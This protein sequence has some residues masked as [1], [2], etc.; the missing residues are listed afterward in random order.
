[1]KNKILYITLIALCSISYGAADAQIIFS[2]ANSSIEKIER[3]APWLKSDNGAGIVYNGASNFSTIKSSLSQD[4]GAYKN[5]YDGDDNTFVNIGT[6]S[7]KRVKDVFFYGK[8]G[9]EYGQRNGQAWLG[10]IYP[11]TTVNPISDSIPGK[12]LREDYFLA[13]KVGYI[14]NEYVS[15]GFNVDYHSAVGAKRV[16]GR[17]SNTMS[18]LAISPGF[19]VN[20]KN[21]IWGLNFMLKHNVERVTYSFLG[22]VTGKSIYYFDGG[23]WFANELGITNTTNLT[24]GYFKD[25]YGIGSQ[26]EFR[27]GKFSF[28]NQYKFDY[29][30]EH[31]YEGSSLT[32]RYAYVDGINQQY[33]GVLSYKGE[34]MNHF[35][36]VKYESDEK[37]S[38]SIMSL[39][40]LIP[41]EFSTYAYFEY[42]RTLRYIQAMK[43]LEVVY[44]NYILKGANDYSWIINLGYQGHLVDKDYRIFPSSYHQDY[45]NQTIFGKITKNLKIGKSINTD[46][47]AGYGITTSSGT[48]LVEENPLSLEAMK[49][50]VNILNWDW[51][52]NSADRYKIDL[53]LKISKT[54]NEKMGRSIYGAVN[55]SIIKA[56]ELRE[57][58]SPFSSDLLNRNTIEVRLGYN[59]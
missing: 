5:F 48:K 18:Y 34:K 57:T 51:A 22:D 38:Y 35:I 29:L 53:G 13:T 37:F 26:L 1:M 49:M 6:E 55:Y 16:D 10:T 58:P 15:L 14:F 7:Y 40:E 41:G 56:T 59:F 32:K 11:N 21:V 3:A 36:D 45:L 30:N 17:N 33:N 47:Y 27:F 23:L 42:G 19:T 46:L 52:Y 25:F 31:D 9:Y 28:F 50:N 44:S 8:F 39:Y 54:L 12:F 2:K 43:N 20:L 24:R 4:K